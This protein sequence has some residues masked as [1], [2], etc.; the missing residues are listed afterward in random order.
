MAELGS[1]PKTGW[2]KLAPELLV[3][4]IA[5]SLAFWRDRLGFAIAYA[6]PE[7]GFAYLERP[8]G[9]QIMLCQRSGSWESG[10]LDIPYGRGVMLQ[11]AVADI[12]PVQHSLG[13]AGWALYAG[14][15]DVWR[16]VGDRKAGQREIFVQ[17]PD[18][19]LI[20][21]AQDLGERPL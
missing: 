14:P 12:E 9:A 13:A 8:E 15:R 1:P 7:Q 16:D 20:M 6:R 10:P 21:L 11:V 3:S 4:D 2:A 17:D 5:A 19:Y 18:G